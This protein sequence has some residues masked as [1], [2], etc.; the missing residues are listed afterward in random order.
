M[1]IKSHMIDIARHLFDKMEASK[2]SI[3]MTKSDLPSGALFYEPETIDM[4][5]ESQFV[6]Q[7][8][9]KLSLEKILVNEDALNY[10][11]SWGISNF[12]I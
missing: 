3:I 9:R 11:F 1:D 7:R 8:D 2:I 5:D 6:E 4:I 12:M 10:L